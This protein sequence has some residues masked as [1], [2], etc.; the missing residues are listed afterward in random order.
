MNKFL[1]VLGTII[2]FISKNLPY[3]LN[4]LGSKSTKS[5]VKPNTGPVAPTTSDDV[6]VVVSTIKEIEITVDAPESVSKYLSV[7]EN[8]SF[9][10]GDDFVKTIWNL[11][12]TAREN[13]M[14]KEFKNGNIPE[15]LKHLK[16]I[17]VSDGKNTLKYYVM[18]D[19][20]SIGNNMN[21]FR[22]PMYPT[23][24][25]KVADLYNCTLPTKKMCEDIWKAAEVKLAPAPI[26]YD[27]K[28]ETTGRY[29]QHN[30]IVN[31]QLMD[32]NSSKLIAGHKKDIII[33]NRLAPNNPN[34][35]VDIFGWFKLT[36]APIQGENPV[37]HSSS[38]S[39]YSH[40][41]RLVF[42][43]VNLNGEIKHINEIFD[44]PEFAKLLNT[45]GVL[46]FK[47]Y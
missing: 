37:S 4:L 46:K 5:I 45:D 23:T 11:S 15:N 28:M 43:Q 10:T 30:K 34:Q 41:V 39:D 21:Y 14:L 19:V 29:D 1:S 20:L 18:N 12:G 42:N 13:F 44:N 24:A 27:N 2:Q 3:L 6:V 35:R 32:K 22:C 31:Q 47:R 36:G 38:Y 8:T 9:L 26:T 33:S 16:E 7:P 25:Q 40:G 17:T